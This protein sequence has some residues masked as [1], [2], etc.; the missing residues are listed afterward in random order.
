[1]KTNP[2]TISK[3]SVLVCLALRRLHAGSENPPYRLGMNLSPYSK[4]VCCTGRSY[5]KKKQVSMIHSFNCMQPQAVNSKLINDLPVDKHK[6]KLLFFQSIYRK[7]TLNAETC[8][9]CSLH[10]GG[11]E[12]QHFLYNRTCTFSIHITIRV[13]VIVFHLFA[14]CAC[15]YILNAHSTAIR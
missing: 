14:P 11:Q 3:T 8:Y 1:M 13:F 4:G 2:L 12:V 7:K 10:K 6:S 15:V 5:C 9:E